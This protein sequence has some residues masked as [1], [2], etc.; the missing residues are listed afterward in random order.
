M[1]RTMVSINILIVNLWAS[2]E[3]Q[4][5]TTTF[6]LE[7]KAPKFEFKISYSGSQI[8]SEVLVTAPSRGSSAL[9]C[10]SSS[11]QQA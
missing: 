1:T 6:R 10:A 5:K 11:A 2:S 9:N 8:A 3:R 7:Y 4:D